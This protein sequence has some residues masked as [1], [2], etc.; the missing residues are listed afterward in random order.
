VK[1]GTVIP[2]AVLGP[3]RLAALPQVPTTAEAGVADFELV[4]FASLMAPAGT[5]KAAVDALSAVLA[6]VTALPEVR[7]RWAAIA[8]E[9]AFA[10]P[11]ATM[12]RITAEAKRMNEI[13][14]AAQIKAD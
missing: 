14:T 8:A 7:E 12:A 9:P 6:K 3:K 1:N 4:Q 13:V 5:P 11:S 10:T 2:L